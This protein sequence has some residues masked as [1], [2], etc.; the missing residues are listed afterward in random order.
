[1]DELSLSGDIKK[2]AKAP[3]DQALP[4]GTQYCL[5]EFEKPV[6]CQKGT[7]ASKQLSLSRNFNL[8]FNHLFF[9][10]D[11]FKARFRRSWK[12]LPHRF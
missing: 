3:R 10:A 4:R 12:C 6:L 1:M 11:W 8:W 7:K 9:A 5:I 2:T